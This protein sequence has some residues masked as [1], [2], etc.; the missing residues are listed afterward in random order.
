MDCL[1]PFDTTPSSVVYSNP[2]SRHSLLAICFRSSNNPATGV[3][4]V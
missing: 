3:Y 4:L 1:A 2:F